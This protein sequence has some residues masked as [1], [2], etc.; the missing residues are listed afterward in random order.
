MPPSHA[1][2]LEM[3]SSLANT[4]IMSLRRMLGLVGGLAVPTDPLKSARTTLNIVRV[5]SH[6]NYLSCKICMMS[7]GVARTKFIYFASLQE[8]C[9]GSSL[10]YKHRLLNPVFC[11]P[12]EIYIISSSSYNYLSAPCAR[13]H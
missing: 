10:E 5:T 7:Q 9:K 13:A 6:S 11:I 3:I 2:Q 12:R 1:Q 8:P 4:R